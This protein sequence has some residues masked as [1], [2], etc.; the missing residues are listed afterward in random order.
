MDRLRKT[1]I[2]AATAAL[3]LAVG[4][5]VAVVPAVAG[6]TP[7]PPLAKSGTLTLDAGAHSVEFT[8]VGETTPT[9]TQDLGS[10]SG[11][12]VPAS[13]D[14]LAFAGL[15]GTT[16]KPVGLKGSTIGV[17]ER[18]SALCNLVDAVSKSGS[19]TL[20]LTLA[21]GLKNFAGEPLFA[22]SAT[23]S[24][25]MGVKTLYTWNKAAKVEVTAY[26]AGA[27]V[28]EAVAEN[29]D[30]C[31]A[32]YGDSCTLTI[33][34]PPDTYFDTLELKA[35]QGAF[36]LQR[37]TANLV[38]EVDAV[39]PCEVGSFITSGDTIVTYQGGGNCDSF[40]VTLDTTDKT[41][42]FLKPTSLGAG[43]KFVVSTDWSIDLPSGDAQVPATQVDFTN[44]PDPGND[45]RIGWCQGATYDD[46]GN[47]T[48]VTQG[49][50][51]IDED[52]EGLQYAC[53]GTQKAQAKGDQ[54]KVQEQIFLVG[55][56][57]MRKP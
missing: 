8:D 15:V 17:N 50:V 2:T 38:S 16:P 53:V 35:L 45:I 27:K 39:L 46:A 22:D 5:A 20:T 31:P 11:C 43:S 55:D 29:G 26:R 40:G 18:V 37:A 47:L 24:L 6:D 57:I 52:T 28:S 7:P 9:K 4:G 3:A 12:I 48:D 13:G 41:V 14:L 51:D 42:T 1:R 21:P 33:T 36:G 56:I 32:G 25:A 44:T 19:E 30:G 34:A 54:L 10:G 49:V 23:V